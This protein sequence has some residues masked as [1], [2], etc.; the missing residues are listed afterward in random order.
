VI[1]GQDRHPGVIKSA[2][3]IVHSAG[4]VGVKNEKLAERFELHEFY[5]TIAV[6]VR[7]LGFGAEGLGERTCEGAEGAPKIWAF[8][9]GA[10]LLGRLKDYNPASPVRP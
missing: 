4:M 10:S 9:G 2:D 5:K 8:Q 3:D 7:L 6:Q 1:F